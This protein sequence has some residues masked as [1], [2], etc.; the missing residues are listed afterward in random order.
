MKQLW[1]PWRI[2]FITKPK[3]SN[4][5]LC[6]KH[7]DDRDRAN[8]ILYRTAYCFV[9]MNIY[10]YN[11]G[12]LLISPY[13]HTRTLEGLN[14]PALSDLIRVLKRSSKAVQRALSP[15]GMNIGMNLG[16]VAGAGIADHLHFHIVPRWEGDTNFM[17]VMG[18]IRVIPEHLK[19]TYSKLRSFFPRYQNRQITPKNGK[20][21]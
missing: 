6:L 5:I 18:E 4:C 15:E 3:P 20:R 12:H 19:G 14:D 1:A 2:E 16:K 8:Y 21:R 13:Q 10:P 17:A 9:M 11:N 7:Q